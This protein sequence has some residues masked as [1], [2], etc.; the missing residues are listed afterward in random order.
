MAN[1]F[2]QLPFTF[3]CDALLRDLTRCLESKWITHFNQRDYAGDWTSLALRSASGE[4]HDISSVPGATGYRNTPVVDACPYFRSVLETF[5]C[6]QESARLLRLAAGSVIHEHRD[7][8]ASYSDG[9]FRVH[10]PITSNAE[11][12]F[13]IDRHD[14]VMHPGECWYADFGLPHR[15]TNAGTTD[16]VHL[17]IDGLRNAWSD[18]VFARAGYDFTLE[19]RPG[20]MDAET[21]RRVIETLRARGT[22]TD[23]RLAAD[24]E[25]QAGGG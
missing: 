9:F 18:E 8:G 13:V 6:E 2:L 21:T 19:R 7:P 17:V 16:R 23:L 14:L 1:R 20:Q 15:V 11:T 22:E 4:A 10:I 12:S 24:L 25:K 5:S 3:E